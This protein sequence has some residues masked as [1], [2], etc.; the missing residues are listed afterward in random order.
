VKEIQGAAALGIHVSRGDIVLGIESTAHTFGV[1]LLRGGR[2]I[3]ADVRYVYRPSRTLGIEPREAAEHHSRVAGR[4][5]KE[6]LDKAGI[7]MERVDA[8]AYSMGPGLGP[9]LRVGATVARF[10]AIYY[11]K[12]LYPVHHGIGHVELA[13]QF[14]GMRDPLVVLVSGGHTSIVGFSGG[15]WRVYGE[16]LDITLGNLLDMFAREAGIPFPGGPRVEELASRGGRY[17]RMP[18]CVKGNNVVYSGLLTYATGLIGKHRLED[19]CYSLQEAAFSSLVEACE[20]ALVQLGKREVALTGGVASNNCLF[21]KMKELEG[22]HGVRVD[23]LEKRLNDDN[24]VQ[25]AVVGHLYLASGAD[26]C[27]PDEAIV[28]QRVRLEEVEVPWRE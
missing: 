4:A 2:E 13:A 14:L 20:R 5:V 3:L 27:P 8:I 24:G 21:A 1:A 17:I 19:I 9:C 15:R 12:P 22:L 7:S 28:R 10:L 16:T 25:I 18:Y 6:A 26:P 11:R 23:R